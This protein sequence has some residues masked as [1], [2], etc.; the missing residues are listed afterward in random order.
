M[1]VSKKFT[2]LAIGAGLM[3]FAAGVAQAQTMVIATDRQGSLMNRVGTAMAKTL[4]DNSDMRFVVRP[5]A[6]PD[7]YLDAHNNGEIKLAVITASSIYL[8]VT[9]GNKAKKKRTNYRILRAGPNV[10][11]LG[12]IVRNDSPIKQ[13]GDLKGK[14]LTS[15][16]GGHST[17]PH[18]IATGLDNGGITWDD[19]VKVPVTGVVDGI[20][21]FGAGRVDS[22]WGAVGMPIIREIHAKNKVRFLSFDNSPAK[23]A[24]MREMMFPGLQLAHFPKPIPPLGIMGPTNL[25]TYDT[26]LQASKDMDNATAKKITEAMWKGTDAFTKSSPVFRGFQKKAAVTLFPMVPYHP[27]AVEFYKAQG[28]WTDDAMKA[29]DKATKMVM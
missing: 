16:F 6:G 10:L 28:L 27:A 17:L 14:K 18:S 4:T 29:N 20:K 9:G 12:L 1:Y 15:D 8:E 11:R 24:K 23:L 5:F 19:V 13:V 26:Y 25:I 3:T 2:A 22:S 21:T 7:A